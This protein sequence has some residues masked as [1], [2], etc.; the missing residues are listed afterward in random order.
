[1]PLSRIK[2]TSIAD[3]SVTNLKLAD[4]TVTAGSYGSASSVPVVTVD[5]QGRLTSA[6]AT[7]VAGGQFIDTQT[8][9]A[10]YYNHNAI[11]ANIT[12]ASTRNAFSAGP[13]TVSSGATVTIAAGGTYT[14]I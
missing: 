3:D 6:S 8:V 10:V 13:I 4:T 5:A 7:A 12:I 1:M 14:L 2:T 11:T 9:K